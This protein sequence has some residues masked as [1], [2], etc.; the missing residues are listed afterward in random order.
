MED[1]DLDDLLE[2]ALSDFDKNKTGESC[3]SIFLSSNATTATKTVSVNN[4]NNS[5]SSRVSIEK[6]NLYVDDDLDYEDRPPAS[7]LLRPRPAAPPA[8]STTS[9]TPSQEASANNIDDDLKMFEEVYLLF[10]FT[11]LSCQ[12]SKTNTFI[13][14][15]WIKIFGDAKTTASMQHLKQTLDM[16]KQGDEA[17]LLANFDKVNFTSPSMKSAAA[18]FNKIPR[19]DFA[20]RRRI[21]I[22]L[23]TIINWK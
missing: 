3:S 9:S 21:F 6:M 11:F 22:L 20:L 16:F 19:N 1:K 10:I 2:S 7:A 5:L 12:N 23:M 4:D 14:T 8:T 15:E 18:A 17:Q 13:W